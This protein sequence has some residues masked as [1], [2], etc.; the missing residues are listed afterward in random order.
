[1]LNLNGDLLK[2]RAVL[3][4]ICPR[5]HAAGTIK[6]SP[7]THLM[8]GNDDQEIFRGHVLTPLCPVV[9]MVVPKFKGLPDH[10]R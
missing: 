9:N 8:V 10:Y 3:E 6:R 1:V 5:M 4:A 2:I 7:W